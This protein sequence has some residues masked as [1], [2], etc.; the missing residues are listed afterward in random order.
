[1]LVDR[2]KIA[3]FSMLLSFNIVHASDLA[4]TK[5]S[6]PST[7]YAGFDRLLEDDQT[8]ILEA[9]MDLDPGIKRVALY[10]NGDRLHRSIPKQVH[11]MIVEGFVLLAEKQNSL[12]MQDRLNVYLKPSARYQP[13]LCP[14]VLNALYCE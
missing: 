4:S 5:T 1:M 11:Q 2:F 8:L 3:L 9:L 7:L 12:F 13:N 14:Q 10:H 6:S